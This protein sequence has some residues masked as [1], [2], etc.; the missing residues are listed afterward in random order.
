MSCL[1]VVMNWWISWLCSSIGFSFLKQLNSISSLGP[2]SR[3]FSGRPR[4]PSSML[5]WS[6]REIAS[7]SIITIWSLRLSSFSIANYN[8]ILG[9]DLLAKIPSSSMWSIESFFS[10]FRGDIKFFTFK[11]VFGYGL[12]L[13]LSIL[14][15]MPFRILSTASKPL[16]SWLSSIDLFCFI[17]AELHLSMIC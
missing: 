2:S 6:A 17:I 7:A 3:I 13:I 14:F 5:Y 4:M 8:L 9:A 12:R 15:W 10:F 16:L 1:M 11:S